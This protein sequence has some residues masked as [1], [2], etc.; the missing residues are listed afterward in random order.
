MSYAAMQVFFADGQSVTFSQQANGGLQRHGCY[1]RQ[2]IM[3]LLRIAK[4]VRKGGK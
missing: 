3:L 1:V 2:T 4:T